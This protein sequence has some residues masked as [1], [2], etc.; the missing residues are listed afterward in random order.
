MRRDIVHEGAKN[1][2]YEI[3]EIVTVAHQVRDLGQEITW[4]NI[5]D[6]VQKGEAITPWIRD[7]LHG[8]IDTPIS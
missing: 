3:R 2:R 7:I 4:E 1:L 5:G 8:L 6:P